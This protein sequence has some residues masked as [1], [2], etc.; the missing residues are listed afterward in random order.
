M[1]VMPGMGKM[2]KQAS[3]MGMDDSVFKKQIALI[4]S[5]TKRER[6]N[7]KFYRQVGKKE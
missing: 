2:A 4:N 1:G 5:M 7:L 6:A 3:E